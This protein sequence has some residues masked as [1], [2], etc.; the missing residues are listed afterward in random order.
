ML[1]T[2]LVYLREHNRTLGKEG[3]REREK[4]ST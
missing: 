1:G 2:K 4:V 3:G